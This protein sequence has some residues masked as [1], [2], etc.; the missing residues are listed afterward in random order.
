MAAAVV[1]RRSYRRAGVNA[2]AAAPAGVRA[3]SLRMA[4]A[5]NAAAA[6]ASPQQQCRRSLATATAATLQ[7]RSGKVDMYPGDGLQFHHVQLYVRSPPP[8]TCT[9]GYIFITR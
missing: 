7:P 9:R 5:R 6:S 3:S 2:A 1:V 4:L 8:P